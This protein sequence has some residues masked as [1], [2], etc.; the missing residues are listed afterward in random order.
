[1]NFVFVSVQTLLVLILYSSRS[2][3]T[4]KKIAQVFLFSAE[5][6]LPVGFRGLHQHTDDQSDCFCLGSLLVGPNPQF[7][8]DILSLKKSLLSQVL[9]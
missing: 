1:M 2:C 9:T 5:L 8:K 4:L 7:W 6:S 3:R